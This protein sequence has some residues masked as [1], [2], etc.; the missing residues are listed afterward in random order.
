[1]GVVSYQNGP[2]LAAC[3]D[4]IL[5]QTYPHIE[6]IIADDG[7]TDESADIIRSYAGQHDHIQTFISPVNKGVSHNLDLT[8]DKCNGEFI[9]L[10]AGDDAMYPEKIERQVAFLRDN[11]AYGTCFHNVDVYDTVSGSFLYNWF[12]RYLP[13][14]SAEEALFTA[15]WFFKKGKK[16]KTPS[17]SWFGRADYI[18][19]SHNDPRI[20][21]YHEFIFTMSMY[22]ANP[23]AKW[24]CL[25]EPLG[26]YRVHGA[27]MSNQQVNWLKQ[28][29]EVNINYALAAVKFPQYDGRIRNEAAY[30]WFMQLLYDQVPAEHKR[31][32]FRKFLRNYGLPKYIYLFVCKLL[33]SKTFGRI[34]KLF[35]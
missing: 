29:E 31:D 25:P 7:S 11:P 16:R 22:A 15:N 26:L 20:T 13:T 24:Y 35:R 2:F 32:Y 6:I 23:K 3:L 10:I 33:L 21:R 8:V 14:R 28:A 9:C 1:M 30:W 17:G 27:S 18:K 34:R 5:A 19:K 12:D 4:S